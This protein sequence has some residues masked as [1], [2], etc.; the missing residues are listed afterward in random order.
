MYRDKARIVAAFRFRR[1]TR[2]AYAVFNSLHRVVNIGRLASYIAD[3]QL[4]K[5]T[6]VLVAFVLGTAPAL[7][8]Q[9]EEEPESVELRAVQVVAPAAAQ[10]SPEPA[11]VVTAQDLSSHTVST[12]SDVVALVAGLDMRVRGVGDMQGD[13]SMRGGTFDQMLI[14]VNGIN[15]TD[16][17]T[18]HHNL[19]IPIDVSMVERVE[20]LTPSMLM[21]RGI[22]AFCGAVN[23]VVGE[24]YRDRLIAEVTGGSHGTARVSALATKCAGAWAHTVA[25]TYGRSDG[26][27]P[28]TDY[29]LA[30][31]YLQSLRR[32]E[33][34][35][36]HLQLGGQAKGFGSQAFYSTTYPD[37]YEATRCLTASASY[38]SH[39]DKVRVEGALYG[40]LHYDRFELFREGV[41]VPPDWYTGH[42]YHLSDIGGL[43]WRLLRDIG[44]GSLFVGAELRHEGIVSNV[45]GTPSA[46]GLCAPPA[47]YDHSAARLSPSLFGGYRLTLHGLVLEAN[48]L[49]SY[50]NS[51]GF[52]YAA[53]ADVAWQPAPHWRLSAAASRTYRL[54]SFTDLYYK[55]A[56]QIANP[57]LKEEHSTALEVRASY[58]AEALQLLATAYC[59]NGREIID[60]VRMPSEEL[61]CSM[62]HSRV[63]AAGTELMLS[64]HCGRGLCASRTASCIDHVDVS[65]SFCSVA[66]DAGGYLSSYILDYLR[67]KGVL[68]V[69]LV[70]ARWFGAE[71]KL[72]LRLKGDVVCRQREGSYVDAA[73]I[74]THY[75]SVVLVNASVEYPL[76]HI[77]LFL[78]LHNITNRL[79]CDHGGVPQPG[80]TLLVGLVSQKARKRAE[81]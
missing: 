26:Y 72:P 30:S 35:S 29:R 15:L 43:R 62:N 52:N 50:N 42:N 81:K 44:R 22:V 31:L 67:H 13:I 60:W 54:P 41:A 57:D 45:L 78:Q 61:W 3:C 6:G 40:R 76:R 14:L 21:A 11:L 80:A 48:M 4:C 58:T 27:M 32:G 77:T 65:Y 2:A 56:S 49:G 9:N 12:M 73:G 70:P 53:S 20:L 25:A 10:V 39:G 18:G 36:W 69:A 5:S 8:A 79:Y 34:G 17:Q 1:F 38:V 19:D 24:S 71:A 68:T 46:T 37:Q 16:A 47:R 23:I 51:F 64:W 66:Q 75:G 55:G 74:P 63:D 28:N 33:R 7:Y 59:R